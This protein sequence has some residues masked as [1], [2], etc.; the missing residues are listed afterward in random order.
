MCIRD[1]SL[2]LRAFLAALPTLSADADAL[3]SEVRLDT[4]GGLVLTTAPTETG[5]ALDVRLGREDIAARL[6]R[7]VAFWQQAVLTRPATRYAVVDVRFDGQVV[8]REAVGE[9]AFPDSTR[10]ASATGPDGVDSAA[11][12]RGGV[13]VSDRSDSPRT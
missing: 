10:P 3:V 4:D 1:S 13:L 7:L 6:D 2:A 11:V 5:A 9:A 12:R 8:T